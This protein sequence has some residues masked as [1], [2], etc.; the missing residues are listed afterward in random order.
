MSKN[1]FES[2]FTEH[3]NREGSRDL[4]GW[5]RKSDFFTAPAST[6]FHLAY[7]GGLVEHSIN[8]YTRLLHASNREYDFDSESV[9]ICGLLHDLCKVN[10]YKTEMRNKKENGVWIQV[11]HYIT[12]DQVPYGHGE[13]SVYIISGFMRLSREEAM[14]IRWHMGYSDDSFKA[15]MQTV[16]NAFRQYPL[17]VFLHMADLSATFI[18]E[19][20]VE[21]I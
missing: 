15:G 5:L 1:E 9:A 8:V 12:E 14:A 4:L 19:N 18:D 3:I 2:I 17:A 6:R 11:P 21:I 20:K 16:S 7:E 10:L 13:K